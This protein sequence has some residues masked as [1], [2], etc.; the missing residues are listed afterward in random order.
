MCPD[1]LVYNVEVD[2]THTY[3]IDGG[4]VVHNCHHAS[5]PTYKQVF[6]W[7][8][9]FDDKLPVWGFTATMTREQ[10]GLAKVWQKTAYTIGLQE[11]VDNGYLVK[12]HAKQVRIPGMDLDQAKVRHGDFTTQ[13][14]AELMLEGKT[15]DQ[16]AE[17]YQDY[18]SDRPGLVFCPDIE[19]TMAMAD[20]FN[21]R[22][23]TAEP[24][25]G[26]MKSDDRH[27]TLKR[28]KHGDTQVL[29]N[30]MVLTEGFDEPKASCI[31]IARP[32]KSRGLYAQMIGRGMRTSPDTG[33]Q[34]LLILDVH[35]ATTRHTL[36]T[37]DDVTE[38]RGDEDESDSKPG[39]DEEEEDKPAALDDESGA[40]PV[41]KDPLQIA[42][43]ADVEDLFG[44]GRKKTPIRWLCS[45]GGIWFA[46]MGEEGKKVVSAILPSAQGPGLVDLWGMYSGGVYCR[47]NCRGLTMQQVTDMLKGV[48]A[49]YGTR[50]DDPGAPWRRK[51][52][53]S[54][55][56]R[57][58]ANRIVQ[59]VIPADP[60]V[61]QM[62]DL[63]D[64]YKIGR[65]VDGA[66]Q[67][68]VKGE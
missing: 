48:Q 58:Y 10:G 59:E 35:G 44:S 13:S 40:M 17:A 53:T 39:D 47:D 33:K 43:W 49:Q 38:G 52:A 20:A 36:A 51:P 64:K 66:L 16:I 7:Y 28:F 1:G 23:I 2:T 46:P 18:A 62:S 54:A 65:V 27:Q 34:D 21:K 9:A 6:D 61:G 68:A 26:T 25:W 14:L 24:V 32:T 15:M 31:V 50:L 60:T 56:Q 57:D 29:I 45:P 3:L 8:G 42:G 30:C 41:M 63:I 11:L 5:A 67:Q 12:P 4:L 19:T 55:K 37:L 22:N